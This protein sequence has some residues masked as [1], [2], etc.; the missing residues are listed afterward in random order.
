MIDP[1]SEPEL[2][3]ALEPYLNPDPYWVQVIR[4]ACTQIYV[5]ELNPDSNKEPDPGPV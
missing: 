4:P 2:L 3:T 1:Y 5:E